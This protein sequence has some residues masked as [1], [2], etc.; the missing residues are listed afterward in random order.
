[1]SL[2]TD[3]VDDEPFT[4]VLGGSSSLGLFGLQTTSLTIPSVVFKRDAAYNRKN[5]QK[6]RSY[7]K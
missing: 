1:M 3:N 5:C 7:I 6:L 4:E 2:E